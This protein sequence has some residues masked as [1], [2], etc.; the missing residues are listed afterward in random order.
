MLFTHGAFRASH[1]DPY[2]TGF[3]EWL[4]SIGFPY[5]FYWAA[6][7]TI[8]ELIAPWFL[9]TRRFVTLACLGHIVI[10]ALGMVLVHYPDGWFVVGAGRNGMEY[11]VM[12]LAGLVAV[13]WAYAPRMS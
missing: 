8:Y 4:G 9:L 10:V 3:G 7:V 5:G 6:A 1:W 13:A 11:S 12:L 2:V